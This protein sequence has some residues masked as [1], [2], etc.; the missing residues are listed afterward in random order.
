MARK[1]RAPAPVHARAR[2]LVAA[3]QAIP[4]DDA[5][6]LERYKR[7]FRS[8]QVW[9]TQSAYFAKEVPEIGFAQDYTRDS[10]SRVVL[11]PAILP[12][13]PSE[14]PIPLDDG[15]TPTDLDRDLCTQTLSRLEPFPDLMGRTAQMLDAFGETHVVLY[16]DDND[17]DGECVRVLSV[18]ELFTRDGWWYVRDDEFDTQ[19]YPLVGDGA[20]SGDGRMPRGDKDHPPLVVPDGGFF[21]IWQP[22]ATYYYRPASYMERL[23]GVSD[24]LLLLTQL[25]RGIARSRIAMN[26]RILGI[27]D[28][29]SL[30]SA[31]PQSTE[32]AG[33]GEASVDP[34]IEDLLTAATA[35]IVDHESAAA[36]LPIII[37]GRHE[38]LKDGIVSIDLE[39]KIDEMT[40]KIRQE[41]I[42]RIA[43]GVNLPREVVLGIGAT[44]HWNAEEIRNQAWKVHL[45]PRAMAITAAITEAFYRPQLMAEGVDPEIVRRCVVAYD[46]SWFIGV[47]DLAE[48]ADEAF[49]RYA[50]SYDAYRRAKGWDPDDA[51]DEDEV[52]VRLWIEQQQ[53]I[54]IREAVEA[55]QGVEVEGAPQGEGDQP[56][57]DAKVP[58]VVAPEKV[59]GTPA[60]NA[61]AETAPK[62]PPAKAAASLVASARSR[63]LAK[64]GG[65]LAGIE[66][67]LRT[68]LHAE[69]NAVAARALEKAGAK[70]Q[71]AA[72][73]KKADLATEMRTWPLAEV[74][75]NVGPAGVAL[76]GLR[77]DELLA[78]A[79][80]GL[81]PRYRM[82]VDRAQH[83]A[84]KAA[85][86]AVDGE[87]DYDTLDEALADSRSNGWK[88]MAAGLGLLLARALYDPHPA[89]PAV[90]EFDATS[91]IPVGLVRSSLNAAGGAH[92]GEPQSIED[93]S[94]LVD[95]FAPGDRS[96]LGATGGPTMTNTFSASLGIETGLHEW[97]YGDAVRSREFEPHVELDGLEFVG[98]DDPALANTDSWPD[99]DYFIPG[100]HEGCQ[101]DI[102]TTFT[103]AAGA[104]GEEAA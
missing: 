59:P 72:N 29:F 78:G 67:D 74:T 37:R 25:I 23:L 80:A 103:E 68:R 77:D 69:A 43:N 41:L 32:D 73:R 56:I 52:K 3:G 99:V 2:A 11:L 38:L 24:E 86:D 70:V 45:E 9:Q 81:E 85:A 28:E 53:K 63:R 30:T 14:R 104:E 55:P 96:G 98:W 62:P 87:V 60:K 51:P 12:D 10:M 57:E 102:V 82:L 100:D 64:L 8:T 17:V 27:A 4:L 92:V 47:P 66:R 84:A 89:A 36:A 26:G 22:D 39:R 48:S 35:A 21:R 46:P 58:E 97:S 15:T 5:K 61:P 33:D 13:D 83:A 91:L 101:C 40:M 76:L 50:I 20:P 16:E 42:E 93:I 1:N 6:L 79:L 71:A 44:N 75:A 94:R 19:G 65:R 34:F 31:V 7:R 49:D 95:V 88:V 54:T 18:E 90:G